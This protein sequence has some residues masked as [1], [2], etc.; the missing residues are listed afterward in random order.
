M[1]KSKILKK[2]PWKDL[3]Y[4]RERWV[5]VAVSYALPFLIIFVFID[6]LILT[7][8]RWLI[9]TPSEEN[10]TIYVDYYSII[11]WSTILTLVIGTVLAIVQVHMLRKRVG[12]SKLY[13]DVENSAINYFA[14]KQKLYDIFIELNLEYDETYKTGFRDS[15]VL[16]FELPSIETHIRI[17][18]ATDPTHDYL[19]V[20][21]TCEKDGY[22]LL[23]EEIKKELEASLD[24]YFNEKPFTNIDL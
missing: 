9:E 17:T 24:I 15:W 23:I 8:G 5:G 7:Y 21:V 6:F 14:I 1:T 19:F 3:N 13:Y 12:E 2:K 22:I 18:G 11:I 4:N 16:K 20:T 10:T